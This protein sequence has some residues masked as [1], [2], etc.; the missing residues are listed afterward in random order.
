MSGLLR[1]ELRKVLS[2]KLWWGLLIPVVVLSVLVNLFG[3]V[4]TDVVAQAGA[5]D[6]PVPVLLASLAYS[7]GLTGT[8]AVVLGVVATAG[9][10]RHRTITATYLTAPGRGAVLA[11][12]MVVTAALG[13]L[14][15]AVTV[16]A[17]VLAALAGRNGGVFPA[18]GDLVAVSGIG[19]VV[20]ALWA[21]LGA[22]LGTVISNQ[23]G[24]LG[25]A[26]GYLLVG[27]LLLTTLI[28]DTPT[29][30]IGAYLPGNASDS[31]LYDVPATVIAGPRFAREVVQALVGATDPP[32]WWGG[33]LVLA[34]WTAALAGAGWVVGRRRDVT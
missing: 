10:F 4:L 26:L 11:A 20:C 31:A 13:T 27:E 2:T 23:V 32:P 33:L 7:L 12:K 28:S 5:G 15:A 9:E 25:A 1:S 16:L 22:A 19:L 3:A 34:A 6:V 8:L 18:V 29:G 14:Y 17:G 30:R 21:A 24:A